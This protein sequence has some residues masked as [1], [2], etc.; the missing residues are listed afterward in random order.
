MQRHVTFNHNL[1]A[2]LMSFCTTGCIILAYSARTEGPNQKHLGVGKK[3]GAGIDFGRIF[4][5]LK[6]LITVK[7]S[8]GVCT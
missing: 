7:Q 8:F 5:Q 3:L 6:A 4:L 1:V 2:L